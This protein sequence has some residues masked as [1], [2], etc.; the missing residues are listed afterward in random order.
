MSGYQ[1]GPPAGY[2]P[3]QY[4]QYDD[5]F[6]PIG[7]EPEFTFDYTVAQEPTQKASNV[8]PD[9]LYPVCCVDNRWRYVGK[10]KN[11]Q[12]VILQL[13]LLIEGSNTEWE[14]IILQDDWWMPDRKTAP[15]EKS[16][17]ESIWVQQKRIA[18][19]T[20]HMPSGV[21]PFKRE[22]LIGG[23]AV[24]EVYQTRQKREGVLDA[25]GKQMYWPPRNKIKRDYMPYMQSPQHFQEV[26]GWNQGAPEQMFAPQQNPV[27]T[28]L[29]PPPDLPPEPA[30]SLSQPSTPEE[31]TPTHPTDFGGQVQAS[32]E[33]SDAPVPNNS[34]DLIQPVYEAQATE[35]KPEETD[36]DFNFSL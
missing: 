6:N 36:G 7:S 20:G 26:P 27:A 24:V 34:A 5:N 12:R 15:D 8:V 22:I 17:A 28:T 11:Q 18:I 23:R 21:E 25:Q 32:P 9:G 35:V 16:Y 2:D 10:D 29:S 4:Q 3:S 33:V 14:G 30:Q 1:Y 31:G 13:D 19:L